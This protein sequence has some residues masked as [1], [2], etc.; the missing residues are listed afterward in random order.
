MRFLISIKYFN[1]K[2]CIG[3]EDIRNAWFF[4]NPKTP[5]R[6]NT[7]IHQGQLHYR[8]LVSGKRISYRRLKKGLVKKQIIIYL[9]FHLLP[10]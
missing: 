8:L 2:L 4:E 9:P 6:V 10:F 5:V 3:L 1:P 7:V